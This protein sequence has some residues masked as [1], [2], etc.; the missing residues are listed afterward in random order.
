[1]TPPPWVNSLVF[2]G[3][4]NRRVSTLTLALNLRYF[5]IE[6]YCFNKLYLSQVIQLN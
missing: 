5:S 2:R 6:K 1:M 3:L 4:S